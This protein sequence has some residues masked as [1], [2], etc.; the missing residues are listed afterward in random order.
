MIEWCGPNA[1]ECGSNAG[2][3]IE[4]ELKFLEGNKIESSTYTWVLK[5]ALQSMVNT[6]RDGHWACRESGEKTVQRD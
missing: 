6:E 4:N 5:G 3:E 2:R 1:T